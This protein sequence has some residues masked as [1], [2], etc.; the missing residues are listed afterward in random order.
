MSCFRQF[1]ASFKVIATVGQDPEKSYRAHR[2][3]TEGII[4]SQQEARISAGW[5]TRTPTAQD[6]AL[7]GGIGFHGWIKEWD[8]AGSRHLS[9]GCVVLHLYDIS[10]LYEQIPEGVYGSDILACIV[11]QQSELRS[12]FMRME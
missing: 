12:K 2:G 1:V 3:R 11:A 6:T 7:G 8:N 10:R 9:W 5:E 4:S